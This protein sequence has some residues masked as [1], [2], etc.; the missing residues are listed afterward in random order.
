MRGAYGIEAVQISG[1]QAVLPVYNFAG[2]T[3][4]SCNGSDTF[5]LQIAIS[6]TKDVSSVA[7]ATGTG[8]VT[9]V[10]GVGTVA[11]VAD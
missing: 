4:T 3:L 9:F 10:N 11:F 6:A 2:E 8:N 7:V 5:A 1:G